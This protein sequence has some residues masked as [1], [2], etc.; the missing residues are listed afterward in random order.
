[1]ALICAYPM[2]QMPEVEPFAVSWWQGLRRHFVEHGISE[3]QLPNHLY[4][5]SQFEN[6]DAHWR[7]DN[8]LLSQ[9]CGYPFTNDLL[10]QVRYVATQTYHTPYNHGPNYASLVLV[11]STDTAQHIQDM[12]QTRVAVNSDDSQSGYHALRSLIAPIAQGLATQNAA[13]FSEVIT[14]SSHRNSIALVAQGQADLC[15]IDCVTFSLIQAHA[16]A[17]L[18]YLRILAHTQSTPCLPYITSL[19][20]SPEMLKKLQLGLMSAALDPTLEE[21]R[22]ALLMGPVCVLKG[23]HAYQTIPDQAAKA[24]ALG[25]PKLI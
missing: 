5:L 11:R 22:R 19:S 1:M 24:D 25:Y 18:T 2:Y 4:Q 10:G 20:S 6:Y 7:D 15:A 17:E 3:T 9:T 8:L 12:Y 14:S 23:L 13:F 21:T 16:P